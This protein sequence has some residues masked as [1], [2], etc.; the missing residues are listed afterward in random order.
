M[1]ITISNKPVEYSEA[2]SYMENRVTKIISGEESEEIWLLEHNSVF[3]A[4]TSAKP[5]D[6][7]DDKGF[8]IF[9]VGRGGKYTYHGPGQ[10]ICYLMLN[11]KNHYKTP[12]LR[13]FVKDIEQSTIDTLAELGVKSF[14]REGRVG[15]WCFD[16]KGLEKKIGAIGIRVRKWV[17]FHGLSININPNLKHFEGIIPCGISEFGVTSLKELGVKISSNEFDEIFLRNLRIGSLV[18]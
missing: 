11:L 10:R 16:K 13:Q 18:L 1:Q 17:S 14:I 3:T 5:E 9:N 2:L 8:P 6:L 4:G 7:L 12:D 15:I